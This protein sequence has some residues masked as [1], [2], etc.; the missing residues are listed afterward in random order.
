MTCF[1]PHFSL[2][3]L[4]PFDEAPDSWLFLDVFFFLLQLQHKVDTEINTIIL[5]GKTNKQINGYI[6]YW[7][8][9]FKT[10]PSVQEKDGVKQPQW[11]K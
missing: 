11:T 4:T 6:L 2:H 8:N 10:V 1:C 9:C 7:C 3:F 5:I